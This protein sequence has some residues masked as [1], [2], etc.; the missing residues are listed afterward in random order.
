MNLEECN[1]FRNEPGNLRNLAFVTLLKHNGLVAHV[2]IILAFILI[3][4]LLAFYVASDFFNRFGFLLCVS[5]R[6]LEF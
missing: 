1:N 2:R 3:T 6:F 4:V 5:L